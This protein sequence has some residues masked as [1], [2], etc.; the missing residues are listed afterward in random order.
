MDHF[1]SEARRLPNVLDCFLMAGDCDFIL[2]VVARDLEDYRR[3]QIRH[4]TQIEGVANV[5]T[6]I[7][8]ERIKINGPLPI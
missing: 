2:R 1:T 7:P 6:E 5:K 3:F 8:M 4:L